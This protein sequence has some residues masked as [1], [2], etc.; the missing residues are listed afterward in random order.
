MLMY[1]KGVEWALY[2]RSGAPRPKV[3]TAYPPTYPFRK[4]SQMTVSQ[5]RPP[6]R[7]ITPEPWER[8]PSETPEAWQGFEVYRD[9][10]GKRSLAAVGQELGKST[11]LIERWSARWS[12]VDRAAAWDEEE[13]RQWTRERLRQRRVAA[14]RHLE[15]A[16]LLIDKGLARLATLDVNTLTPRQ[17]LEFAKTGMEIEARIYGLYMTAA[18]EQRPVQIVIDGQMLPLPLDPSTAPDVADAKRRA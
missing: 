3:R 8:Q 5:L 4:V 1:L 2:R 14:R 18:D 6:D 17:L 15:A 13:D 11:A 10:K 12:W 16:G 7:S 9:H